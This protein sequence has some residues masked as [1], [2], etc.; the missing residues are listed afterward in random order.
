LAAPAV[1]HHSYAMFDQ[2]K[3]IQVSGMVKQYELVNHHLAS[4]NALEVQA[5]GRPLSL[6]TVR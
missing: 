6:T 1:A 3:V 4:T 5:A 2:S